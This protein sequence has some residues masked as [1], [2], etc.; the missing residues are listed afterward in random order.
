MFHPK[1][2]LR[3]NHLNAVDS[4][5]S[6]HI[7]EANNRQ[8]GDENNANK[9]SLLKQGFALIVTSGIVATLIFALLF[10]A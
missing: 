2:K 7:D 3:G 9:G 1:D 10:I 6:F 5:L 8:T 4:E